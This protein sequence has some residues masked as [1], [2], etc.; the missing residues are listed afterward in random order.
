MTLLERYELR[1]ENVGGPSPSGECS[2]RVEVLRD[3][4]AVIRFQREPG[5]LH[6][7]VQLPARLLRRDCQ[8]GR[9]QQTAL[10]AH[11]DGLTDV[12]TEGSKYV[13]DSYG[14]R[15]TLEA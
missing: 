11:R 12:T 3:H 2:I 1:I 4:P 9:V 7:Q 13:Q 6:L 15:I 5:F 8:R 10:A 14:L